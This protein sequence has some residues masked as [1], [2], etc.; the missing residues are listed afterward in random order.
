LEGEKGDLGAKR[1]DLGA[2]TGDFEVQI[3]SLGLKVGFGRENG[4]LE[5]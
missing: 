5:G 3:V 4:R 1:G 2:K